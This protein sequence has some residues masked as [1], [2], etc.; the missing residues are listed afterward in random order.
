MSTTLLLISVSNP[1]TNS[2]TIGQRQFI[3]NT[4]VLRLWN[5]L[6]R[7]LVM[8]HL[9]LLLLSLHIRSATLQI[10]LPELVLKPYKLDQLV[11]IQPLHKLNRDL[12]QLR[13][14]NQRHLLQQPWHI[15]VTHHTLTTC[16]IIEKQKEWT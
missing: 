5:R 8:W 6:L 3:G 10:H 7:L 12:L 1:L 14:H 13:T 16:W 15:R 9:L 4:R 2:L 11:L